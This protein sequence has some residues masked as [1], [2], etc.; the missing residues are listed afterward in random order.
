M[1]WTDPQAT[2]R[3]HWDPE[4]DGRRRMIDCRRFGFSDGAQAVNYVTS[5]DV[6]GAGNQRLYNYLVDNTGPVGSSG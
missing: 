1:W 6:G 5:H 4:Q 2:D 3:R